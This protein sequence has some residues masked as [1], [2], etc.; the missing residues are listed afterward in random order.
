MFKRILKCCILLL[1]GLVVTACSMDGS[2][3]TYRGGGVYTYPNLDV[4]GYPNNLGIYPYYSD[5]GIYPYSGV[6]LYS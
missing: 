3:D 4:S 5:D 1:L 6:D 2:V